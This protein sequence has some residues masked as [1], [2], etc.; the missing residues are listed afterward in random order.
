MEF[1]WERKRKGKLDPLV[2][3]YLFKSRKITII[4]LHDI[5][6]KDSCVGNRWRDFSKVARYLFVPMM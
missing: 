6:W 4:D 5:N 3:N 1:L 2:Y